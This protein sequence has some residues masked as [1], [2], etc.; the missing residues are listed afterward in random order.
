MSKVCPICRS[1]NCI[2]EVGKTVGGT[3]WFICLHCHSEMWKEDILP[4]TVFNRIT[5]SPEVLAETFVYC[6]EPERFAEC[7]SWR[8]VLLGNISFA[9]REEAIA[10][11]VAKLK[12]VENG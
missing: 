8:S 7:A 6:E 3:P 2:V 4:V 5:S 10:A 9:T 11:T 1:I 12:E